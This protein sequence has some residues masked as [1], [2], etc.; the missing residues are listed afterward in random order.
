MTWLFCEN[1]FCIYQKGGECVLERVHLDIQGNCADCFYVCVEEE[2][3]SNL[4]EEMLGDLQD[5]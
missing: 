3:L 4:K 2:R 1:E 5:S